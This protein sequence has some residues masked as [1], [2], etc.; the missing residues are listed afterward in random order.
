MGSS[1]SVVTAS[2]PSQTQ[3]RGAMARNDAHPGPGLL[4]S[5]RSATESPETRVPM[6]LPLREGS[7][8]MGRERAFTY[9]RGAEGE[10]ASPGEVEVEAEGVGAAGGSRGAEA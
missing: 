1:A 5:S 9:R 7:A 4:S 3:P 10:A 8:W 6:G 2:P